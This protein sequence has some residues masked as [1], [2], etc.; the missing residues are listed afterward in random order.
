[1][2]I[3]LRN[4]FFLIAKHLTFRMA[5]AENRVAFFDVDRTLYKGLPGMTGY[6]ILAIL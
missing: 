3:Y 1:M 6:I 2:P 4:G 5:M